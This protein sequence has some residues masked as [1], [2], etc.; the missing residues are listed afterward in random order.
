MHIGAGWFGF[1]VGGMCHGANVDSS[2]G[3]AGAGQRDRGA[4]PHHTPTSTTSWAPPGHHPGTATPPTTPKATGAAKPCTQPA[5]SDGG[6]RDGELGAGG[7]GAY[8]L[9]WVQIPSQLAALEA[10][11]PDNRSGLP[12]LALDCEPRRRDHAPRASSC[13]EP[14]TVE[15]RCLPAED[16]SPEQPE[17][18]PLGVH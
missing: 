15:A 13:S 2:Q 16:I 12:G 14:G 17:E 18:R 6:R 10:R 1:F 11:A 8:A 7:R 9:V 4:H 3:A 5:A